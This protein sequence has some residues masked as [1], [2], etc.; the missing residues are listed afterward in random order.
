MKRRIEPLQARETFGFWYQGTTDPSRYSE[1]EISNGEVLS[2]VRR[3]L[4][5]VKHV[6]IIPDTFAAANPSKQLLHKS[7]R[8]VVTEYLSKILIEFAFL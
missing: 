6:P 2:R 1:E 5:D 8:F 3:L 4:K 7:S